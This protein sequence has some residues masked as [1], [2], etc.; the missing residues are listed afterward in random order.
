MDAFGG[1]DF[2]ELSRFENEHFMVLLGVLISGII[3]LG[4]PGADSGPDR[5]I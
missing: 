4:N 3:M 2:I 5:V 1:V